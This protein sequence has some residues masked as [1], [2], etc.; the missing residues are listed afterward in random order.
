MSDPGALGWGVI[1]LGFEGGGVQGSSGGSGPGVLA[2]AG[3][4]AA[5]VAN[6]DDTNSDTCV[7]IE[8]DG[9]GHAMVASITDT[10]NSA[11]CVRS[12]T[13]GKGAAIEASSAHGYG[14][15]IAGTVQLLLIPS[16]LKTHPHSSSRGALF[17]D[18]SGHL[19][20]CR[21][22]TSWTQLA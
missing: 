19:W 8:H 20:F 7:Q 18:H 5:I 22:G 13:A 6:S 17:V 14:A 10:A 3:S 9:T 15:K 12:V 4:G 11:S 2:I 1:G 16:D 21:G